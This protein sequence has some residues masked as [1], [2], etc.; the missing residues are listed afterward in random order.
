MIFHGGT[1]V[2]HGKELDLFFLWFS[3][4]LEFWFCFVHSLVGYTVEEQLIIL[5][6]S[7]ELA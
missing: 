1:F 2:K 3:Q 4:F 6:V 5:A 7:Q